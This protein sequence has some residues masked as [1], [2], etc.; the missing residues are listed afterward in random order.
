MNGV[1]WR[2]RLA[3]A[4]EKSGRSMRAVSIAAGVG[5]NYLHG[6][7]RDRKEPTIERL[8]RIC[9]VLNVSLTFVILGIELTQ[10]QERLLL[11]LAGIPDEQKKLLLELAESLVRDTHGNGQT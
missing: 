8:I 11:L 1:E 3:A 10:A 9:N 7:L 5:P 6:I 2:G 4:L